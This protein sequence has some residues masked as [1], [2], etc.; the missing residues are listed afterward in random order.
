MIPTKKQKSVRAEDS[1]QA[2]CVRFYRFQ[3]PQH[4]I[5]S[6]PAGFVFG[7]DAVKRAM[8]ANRMKAM[9]YQVGCPD[10]MIIT[11]NEVRFIEMKVDKGRLTD[12]QKEVH[13]RLKNM[14]YRV[15]VCRSLDEFVEMVKW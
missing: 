2:A 5:M 9:G 12:N 1:L 13:E 10:L 3:Y 6:F 8:T 15:D 11:P 7:G 14:G 4:L